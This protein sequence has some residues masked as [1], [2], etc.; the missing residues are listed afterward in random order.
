MEG[1]ETLEALEYLAHYYKD[2]KYRYRAL[3]YAKRLQ[4]FS[5]KVCPVL[6]RDLQRDTVHFHFVLDSS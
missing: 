1:P 3:V 4:E 5:G 6:A 2:A